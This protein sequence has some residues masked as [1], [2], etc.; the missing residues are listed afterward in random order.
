MIPRRMNHVRNGWY[1]VGQFRQAS[2]AAKKKDFGSGQ[3][4]RLMCCNF[5]IP[6]GPIV[7]GPGG[8]PSTDRARVSESQARIE[9]QERE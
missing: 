9:G 6:L 8:G 4:R 3:R 1:F 5:C 2:S 7:P